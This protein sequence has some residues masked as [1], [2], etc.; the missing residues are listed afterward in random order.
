M[1]IWAG[2]FQRN[3]GTSPGRIGVLLAPKGR[4]TSVVRALLLGSLWAAQLLLQSLSKS[5]VLKPCWYSRTCFLFPERII[6]RLSFPSSLKLAPP[7]SCHIKLWT[8]VSDLR[9]ISPSRVRLQQCVPGPCCFTLK[10]NLQLILWLGTPRS[11][12]QW[13]GSARMEINMKLCKPRISA[14]NWRK[15]LQ[16]SQS[17]RQP[18]VT[19]FAWK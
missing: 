2:Y 14:R 19:L 7:M 5:S 10:W 13:L 11:W 8:E 9:H 17:L 1:K 4:H 18:P 3:W 15:A 16:W 6:L 12:L